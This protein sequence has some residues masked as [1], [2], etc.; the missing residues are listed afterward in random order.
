V[1][2]TH[3]RCP[4][5]AVSKHGGNARRFDG[6][7]DPVHPYTMRTYELPG[8]HGGTTW[9]AHNRLRMGSTVGGS[10][11]GKRVD[12]WSPS[13]LAPVATKCVVALLISGDEQD[14]ATHQWL[15][16]LLAADTPER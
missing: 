16:S 2:F 5:S 13:D 4:V 6:Q 10:S 8:E 14:L 11:G 3:E 15:P 12:I 1:A 9:H 7:L